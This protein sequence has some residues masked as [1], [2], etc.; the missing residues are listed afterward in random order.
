MIVD[1][2]EKSLPVYKALANPVRLHIIRILCQKP[3]SVKALAKQIGLSQPITLRH[4]NQLQE[5]GIVQF[6]REGKNK[7]SHICITEVKLDLP[8]P[9]NTSLLSQSTDIPVGSYVDF[10]VVPTCGIA[11]VNNFIGNVDDPK[12]FMDPGRLNAQIIWFSKGFI[13]YKIGNYLF[14]KDQVQMLTLSGEFGSE[15][16]L[17][18]PDWPSD[19]TFTLNGHELATWTSQ[20]DFADT[21]GKYTP[22]WT[23]A[24]FNQYGTQV[25][26]LV[27]DTGTWIGGSKVSNL[28]ISDLLPLPRRMDLRIEVK[29]NAKHVGGCTI[30]GKKF[31]NIDQDMRLTL[32][33]K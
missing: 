5:A 29:D 32:Y 13:D 15:V 1:L 26:I 10:D 17:S 31:G 27:S 3:Y 16:P 11:D 23:P 33:Y 8:Q 12:Y 19:I 28:T 20:G 24:E 2:S 21:R 9:D 22:R 14:A 25:T 18:N 30:F 6:K 7:V 4:V